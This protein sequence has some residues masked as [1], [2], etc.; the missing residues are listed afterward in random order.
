MPLPNLD[1]P[2]ATD[3]MGFDPD[4]PS[5]PYVDGD[6]VIDQLG[7]RD[8]YLDALVAALTAALTGK[9][10]GT[11]ARLADPRTPTSHAATHKAGGTDQIR[12]HELAAPTADVALG[13][14][15]ITGLADPTGAQDAATKA[16]VDQAIANLVNGAPGALDTIAELAAA[17]GNDP[18]T[19]TTLTT[20]IGQKLAKSANLSDLADPAVA[21]TN[22]GLGS[23]ATRNI[24][25]TAGTAAAGD[26]SR[27]TDSRTPT[28]VAS[29]DLTGT[30]PSPTLAARAVTWAKAQAISTARILGRKTAGSGDVE[31][32]TGTD[33]AAILPTFGASQ[34]GL[35]PAAAASPDSS[36]FLNEAG[37]FTSPPGG[38]GVQVKRAGGSPL[39]SRSFL[40]AYGLSVVDDGT[41]VRIIRDRAIQSRG[42][43]ISDGT[44]FATPPQSFGSPGDWAIFHDIQG[45]PSSVYGPKS[46]VLLTINSVKSGTAGGLADDFQREVSF[47]VDHEFVV[48]D[49]VNVARTG[50]T[51]ATQFATVGAVI[52]AVP[53]S[54]T[55]RFAHPVAY[56]LASSGA[57]GYVECL[58]KA[59]TVIIASGTSSGT[60]RTITTAAAHGFVT[61]QI[62]AI[63]GTS[64]DAVYAV[65]DRA[66][67]VT[68]TTT[69][70]YT[71]NTSSS[72]SCTGGRAEYGWLPDGSYIQGPGPSGTIASG[73]VRIPV[74][75]GQ[76]VITPSPGFHYPILATLPSDWTQIN[77]ANT[78]VN[79]SGWAASN[80]TGRSGVSRLLG[81]SG[82]QS[83]WSGVLIASGR[84]S[85]LPAAGFAFLGFLITPSNGAVRGFEAR[86]SSAG[87][88]GIYNANGG[89]LISATTTVTAGDRIVMERIGR[90]IEVTVFNG[91][92]HVERATVKAFA[93]GVNGTENFNVLDTGFG[94][95]FSGDTAGRWYVD[96]SGDPAFST[97]PIMEFWG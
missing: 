10:D 49:V 70:T 28:G 21:R 61:G 71:G 85:T 4:N 12:L 18:S 83:R 30:Y 46:W 48:G 77:S 52:T 73:K 26:D 47:A 34:R 24:G 66:I 2:S 25:T 75:P 78:L 19:I 31:E 5:A 57:G 6:T 89:T 1:R 65:T 15:K 50:F 53:N 38:G 55:I 17:L 20:L 64:D 69:F 32:L 16:F 37:A 23:A 81:L 42:A 7:D 86:I 92:T 87:T 91:S 35:V 51:G 62:V 82:G 58:Y 68:G 95:G 84:L 97:H 27:L 76:A 72:N 74:L 11:D 59:P 13:S 90:K 36:K 44:G 33:V 80:S 9:V 45:G 39:P 8:E 67:T 63:R 93:Y 29:G 96:S 43:V 79:S 22:L 54:T 41:N 56:S 40:D 94:F 14:R 60:T 88:L 3:L